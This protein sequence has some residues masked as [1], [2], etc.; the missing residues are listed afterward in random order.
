[1]VI[2]VQTT[3]PPPTP[4][5]DGGV[6]TSEPPGLRELA[7]ELGVDFRALHPGTRDLSLGRFFTVE[8]ADAAEAQRVVARLR[9][10]PAIAAAYVKPPDELP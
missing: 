2:T 1:M 6:A 5:M 9:A 7:D 8:V 10:S 3:A 4:V